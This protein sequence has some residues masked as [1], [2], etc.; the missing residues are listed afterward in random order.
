MKKI[1]LCTLMLTL[2]A[3]ASMNKNECEVADWRALG[4]QQGV[5][6]HSTARFDRDS[7]ACA[8]HKIQADFNT[9]KQGHQEGLNNYCTFDTAQTLGGQGAP[10]NEQCTRTR[11][12]AFGEGYQIGVNRYCIYDNGFNN[13]LSGKSANSVCPEARYPKYAEGYKRGNEKYQAQQTINHLENQLDQLQKDM[14]QID[15]DI[16][17]AEA[18]IVS[19]HSTPD[20]RRHALDDI[21]TLKQNHADLDAQ[22]HDISQQLTRERNYYNRL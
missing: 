20:A 16:T 5:K 3:C 22:Y 10:Y 14:Q 1:I 19:A 7:K 9:Y 11:Y 18:A 12:P 6:G 4:Y 17:A 8:K 15:D 21:K 2:T 13:G